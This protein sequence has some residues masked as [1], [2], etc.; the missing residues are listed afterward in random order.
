MTIFV[1]G[2]LQ[3]GSYSAQQ[4][5]INSAAALWDEGINSRADL[6]V[7]QRGAGANM[8][9]DVAVGGCIVT[10]DNQSNQGNY[11]VFNDAVF[12]LTGFTAPGSNSQ[13]DI[14]GIQIN[15]PNAG[16]A[17]GNNAVIVRIAGTS[18]ASPVL[19][20]IPSSCLPI[21]V[22]GPILTSTT[23]ITNAMILTAHSGS[24]PTGVLGIGLVRGF[25][26]PP[27]TTEETWNPIPPNG[28]LF[29]DGSA[30]SRTTYAR[31]FATIGVTFGSGDGSTTFNLP[32]SRGR[33]F[34]ALDNQG[35]SDAGRLSVANTL[36][37]TGGAET[38]ALV[39][40]ETAVKG[41]THTLVDPT[42]THTT[43]AH[44][45]SDAGHSHSDPGHNHTQQAHQHL[46]NDQGVSTLVGS[47]PS[48]SIY[49]NAGAAVDHSPAW[50]VIASNFTQYQ[51]ALN[52]ASLT[53]LAAA[54]TG[55]GATTVSVNGAS[56]GASVGAI[57]D[58]AAGT[59]HNNLQ[60]YILGYRVVRT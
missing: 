9:V 12:N 11:D 41:H 42:H 34:V 37:L 55:L 14:V 22:I 19:P 26:A 10:G 53:G 59:A 6:K 8:S 60:P 5:R 52:V 43:V 17:A 58:G 45:H 48:S 21:A 50:N 29:E 36:G 31:L 30:V 27:G 16:G 24:G 46:S 3:G 35:G 7:S 28:W 23:S 1:P 15:D 47:T 54:T 4:D 13:Y 40:A 33:V 25:R 32:D 20:A 44:N 39:A 57:A 49:T 18:A 51:T 2:W 38:V 56:T